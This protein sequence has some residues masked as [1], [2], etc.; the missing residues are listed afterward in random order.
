MRFY[1]KYIRFKKE[2]MNFKHKSANKN[3]KLILTF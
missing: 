1:E 3:I 2:K